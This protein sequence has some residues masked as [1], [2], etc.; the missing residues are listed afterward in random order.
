LKF[1]AEA[2]ACADRRSVETA[3]SSCGDEDADAVSL[4]SIIPKIRQGMHLSEVNS[5]LA[6]RKPYLRYSQPS[7]NHTVLEFDERL[8]TS[9]NALHDNR[10]VLSFDAQ[11]KV[12]DIIS[13]LCLLPDAE[14]R[15]NFSSISNCYEKRVFPFESRMVYDAVTQLLITSNYQI[16]H[17]DAT[18]LIISAVGVQNIEGDNEKAMFIKL[19]AIFKPKQDT[20]EVIISASFN[21]TEKQKTWVQA[22]FAGVT[23]PVPLPFQEKEEWIYTGIVTPRF[24]L[25]F[26]DTLS[27]LIAREFSTY[28]AVKPAAIPPNKPYNQQLVEQITKP[29][30]VDDAGSQTRQQTLVIDELMTNKSP[31]STATAQPSDN[32]LVTAAPKDS[33]ETIKLR[34]V[35]QQTEQVIEEQSQESRPKVDLFNLHGLAL[36]SE[37]A[38]N[39]NHR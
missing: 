4:S 37:Q 14:Q 8:N 23:L 5:L 34:G 20:T 22:G 39:R 2:A 35:A 11:E 13:S 24:Y 38:L 36:D 26:Y 10:L 17:S 33:D 18:S 19:S 30:R 21:V 15:H 1:D 25:N 29:Y 12:K 28:A 32:Q 3:L 9:N 16:D 27:A 31:D 6:G 7:T